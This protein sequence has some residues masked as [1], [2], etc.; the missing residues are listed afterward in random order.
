MC[1]IEMFRC[2]PIHKTK[3]IHLAIGIIILISLGAC[4]VIGCITTKIYYRC[5]KRCTDDVLNRSLV[6]Y[7]YDN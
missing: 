2:Y 4:F 3:M 6:D 7:L 1:K 5:C